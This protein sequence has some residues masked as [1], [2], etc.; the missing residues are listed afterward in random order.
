MRLLCSWA[1]WWHFRPGF[2]IS[3]TTF[4]RLN[5]FRLSAEHDG[6]GPDPSRSNG[7]RGCASAS[8]FGDGSK[9]TDAW[10]L[11]QPHGDGSRVLMSQPV[12][13]EH[14]RYGHT[15]GASRCAPG[16][17]RFVCEWPAVGIPESEVCWMLRSYSM[18]R[19]GRANLGAR[20]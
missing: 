16:M 1:T 15:S 6:P 5:Y 10:D 14:R 17:L 20:R 12:V 11:N 8:A 3:V 7:R 2:K 9:V 13:A 18:R 4:G 19:P